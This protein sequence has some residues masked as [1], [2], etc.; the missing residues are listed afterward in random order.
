[1]S[2][3]GNHERLS[4]IQDTL[5]SLVGAVQAL[6]K[7]MQSLKAVNKELRNLVEGTTEPQPSPSPARSHDAGVPS[8]VTLP[9][10]RDMKDL[11]S[12]VDSRVSQ[13]GLLSGSSDESDGEE[14]LDRAQA[15]GAV[16]PARNL[17]VLVSYLHRPLP[18]ALASESA[19]FC[20]H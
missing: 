19:H 4:S 18:T 12:Q 7:D 1:M 13:L 14:D 5:A 16:L 11:V 8:L 17:N 2:L 10:L 3:L 6:F 20:S 15:A 9:E